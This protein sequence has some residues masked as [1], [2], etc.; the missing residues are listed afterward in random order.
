MVCLVV[1]F[2]FILKIFVLFLVVVSAVLS[3]ILI[4]CLSTSNLNNQQVALSIIKDF[5]QKLLQDNLVDNYHNILEQLADT[6]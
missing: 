6:S 1:I 2:A 5:S 3:G 4:K